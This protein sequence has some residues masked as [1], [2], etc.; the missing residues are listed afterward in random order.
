[1]NRRQLVSKSFINGKWTAITSVPKNELA[2]AVS[3][4]SFG[5]RH[6]ADVTAHR[7]EALNSAAK[8][9]QYASE[10]MSTGKAPTR[11]FRRSPVKPVE[12]PLAAPGTVAI[13]SRSRRLVRG[14]HVAHTNAG[15][16][17]MHE[18]GPRQMDALTRRREWVED[19][20]KVAERF[21]SASAQASPSDVIAHEAAHARPSKKSGSRPLRRKVKAINAGFA[22]FE[23]VPMPTPDA[24]LAG[25]SAATDKKLSRLGTAEEAHA[26]VL[27]SRHLGHP[28]VSGHSS[29]SGYLEMRNRIAR[30]TRQP[31]LTPVAPKSP[32]ASALAAPELSS[33]RLK[34]AG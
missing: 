13:T 20:Q 27:A 17:T 18:M 28:F 16:A 3:S 5:G 26:D 29:E 2:H 10:A 19:R 23:G 30:G 1:M 8:G 33:L 15:V 34:R 32:R 21:G 24:R 31:L 7:R 4:R 6:L 25:V 22:Q 14:P 9:G 11:L 12:H